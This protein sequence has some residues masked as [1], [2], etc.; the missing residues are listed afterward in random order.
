MTSR[1]DAD[2]IIEAAKTCRESADDGYHAFTAAYCLP[3]YNSE[4]SSTESAERAYIKVCKKYLQGLWDVRDTLGDEAIRTRSW[5]VLVQLLRKVSGFGGSG[6]M[7]KEICQ[8]LMQTH[9]LKNCIDANTWCPTGPGARRGLNRLHRRPTSLAVSNNTQATEARF[10]DEMHALYKDMC[11][12]HSQWC[13]DIGGLE[14]HDIQ[15][16]LCEFD[17]YERVRNGEGGKVR[18]YN[19]PIL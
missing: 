5:E 6:F 1:Y 18:K 17:K 15:F 11:I 16:Q 9:V 2:Q 8:D 12:H 7:A 4:T 19:P 14:L 13:R 3:H 10:L